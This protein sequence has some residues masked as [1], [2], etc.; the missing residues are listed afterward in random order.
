MRTPNL[1]LPSSNDT[2]AYEYG[3]DAAREIE[4]IDERF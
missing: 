4:I 2:E 1:K 3:S